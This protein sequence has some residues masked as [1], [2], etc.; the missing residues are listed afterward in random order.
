MTS[1]DPNIHNSCSAVLSK[2]AV[3][4]VMAKPLLMLIMES[5]PYTKRATPAKGFDCR[6]DL[7]FVLPFSPRLIQLSVRHFFGS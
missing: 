7:L 1:V 4:N 6:S 5:G 3:W 2:C